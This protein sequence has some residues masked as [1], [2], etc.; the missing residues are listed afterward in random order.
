MPFFRKVEHFCRF[1]KKGRG[2]LPLLKKSL[3]ENFIFCAVHNVLTVPGFWL[4]LVILHVWQT[5]EVTSGSKCV[6]VIN[7]TRQYMQGLHRVLNMLEYDSIHL[8]NA[9][10]CLNVPQYPW[11]WLNIAE[12]P[13]ICLNKLFWL[14]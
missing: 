6:R 5:L 7:M 10:I 13:W 12:C 14:C 11:T 8:N 9:W 4:C 3:M 1:S 2:G